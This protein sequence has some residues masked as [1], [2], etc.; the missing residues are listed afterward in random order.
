MLPICFGDDS[1]SDLS[2]VFLFFWE[3]GVWQ[4]GTQYSYVSC[5][6]LRNPH[7]L[8]GTGKL[9]GTAECLGRRNTGRLCF[10]HGL[11]LLRLALNS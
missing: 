11:L 10:S 1:L 7:N 2:G 8:K 9:H 5:P 3:Q 6:S 4:L